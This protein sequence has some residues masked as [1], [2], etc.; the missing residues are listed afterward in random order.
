MSRRSTAPAGWRLP[1]ALV[2][3]RF[4]ELADDDVKQVHRS[5]VDTVLVVCVVGDDDP[6]TLLALQRMYDLLDGDG[7]DH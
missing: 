6:L 5:D 1:T 4:C 7:L 3:H 2:F